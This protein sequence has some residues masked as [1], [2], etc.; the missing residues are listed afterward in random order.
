MKNNPEL[1]DRMREYLKAAMGM[2]FDFEP[3]NITTEGLGLRETYDQY[4]IEYFDAGI[5]I[6][7]S[8][9]GNQGNDHGQQTR[10]KIPV[11]H[12]IEW[13]NDDDPPTQLW[14]K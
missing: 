9:S 12:V 10:I 7:L 2:F 11:E 4:T 13:A 14:E 8:N 6:T 3:L 5:E 1:C